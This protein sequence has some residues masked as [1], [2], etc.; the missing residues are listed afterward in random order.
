MPPCRRR[1]IAVHPVLRTCD[2]DCEGEDDTR[3]D[4]GINVGV[5][6]RVAAA[7]TERGTWSEGGE[8]G[9]IGRESCSS[10][11]WGLDAERISL[12]RAVDELGEGGADMVGLHE[13]AVHYGLTLS[14]C[15][16]LVTNSGNFYLV[17][18][19]ENVAFIS[20]IN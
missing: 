11:E 7:A 10:I 13:D 14:L 6:S 8:M 17:S 19:F 16:G 5:R 12:Q 1:S 15:S 9:M 18:N 3:V 2:V 20:Q 4:T